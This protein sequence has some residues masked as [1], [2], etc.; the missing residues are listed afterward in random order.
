M[1]KNSTKAIRLNDDELT[2]FESYANA[3]GLTFS[4]LCKSAVIEK[5]EDEIDL[6]LAEESYNEYLNDN[7]TLSHKALFDSL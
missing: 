7:E 3:K 5:I 1:R 4:E 2:L 6:K